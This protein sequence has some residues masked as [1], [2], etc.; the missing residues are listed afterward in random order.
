MRMRD[1]TA[2]ALLLAAVSVSALAQQSGQPDQTGEH[3]GQ[4]PSVAAPS[5]PAQSPGEQP[6]QLAAPNGPPQPDPHQVPPQKAV[7]GAAG[8]PAG[9]ANSQDQAPP[10]TPPANWMTPLRLYEGTWVVK[11]EHSDRSQTYTDTCQTSGSRFYECEHVVDGETI[12]L[13][14][15][16]PGDEPGHYYTQSVLPSGTALGRGDLAITGDTWV[17]NMR[18][19]KESGAVEYQRFTRVYSGRDKDT[20]HYVLER[21]DDG[22]H[23]ATAN[24]GTEKRKK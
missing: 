18:T 8:V 9:P 4:T 19:V 23:W 11:G 24:T 20:I 2:A 6:R 15:F 16:V 1:A 10:A 14:V 3:S 17:F 21:S 22:L 13:Q 12:S 7:P 5:A